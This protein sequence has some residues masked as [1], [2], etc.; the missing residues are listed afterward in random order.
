MESSP[1]S[2][3][4]LSVINSPTKQLA[5]CTK[6]LVGIAL[7]VGLW[8]RLVGFNYP[9]F[10]SHSFRQTQTLST[11]EAF[12][13]HGI[14]PLHP[15]TIYMGYPGVFVLEFPVFQALAALLYHIFGPHLELVRILNILMGIA[16]AWLLFKIVS[17]MLD[18]PTAIL[19]ALTYWLAPLNILYQRSM[20][21]DPTAVCC[22]LLAFYMLLLLTS[23]PEEVLPRPHWTYLLTFA[24]STW[25]TAMI[26]AL[27]LWPAVM[28]F[29]FVFLTRRCK[30]DGLILGIGAAFALS[31]VCFLTWNHY[32]AGINNASPITS[33]VNPTALLG[34]SALTQ[35]E[36][37]FIML[38]RR[39]KLWLGLFGALLYIV[40]LWAAWNERGE[41][42]RKRVLMLLFLIPPSYLILFASI[43][44]P[45][46]YYQLIITPFLA[47]ITG[48]GLR[49]LATRHLS[50][51]TLKPAISRFVVVTGSSLLIT[52]AA[53]FYLLWLQAPHIDGRILKF[54]RVCA[55]K[56]QPGAAAMVFV[57]RSLYTISK[58]SYI[59]EFLYASKLW[60]YGR[61]VENAMDARDLYEEALPGFQRLDYVVFYGTERPDWLP[62]KHFR[63]AIDDEASRLYA[64]KRITEL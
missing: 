35:P 37:Y 45:H 8:L 41:Q 7:A 61:T 13:T 40:G 27:Y 42:K 46:E 11:I 24:V 12:Y 14:D 56:F 22:A 29:G 3:P 38:V 36:F 5:I 39:P 2:T 25:L 49:W 62:N 44:R 54:Q 52:S 33:G 48:N 31:G 28:L 47:I 21:I 20:L 18:R 26:K 19:A 6:L 57:D 53:L 10:D 59:P 63:L 58:H 43:N 15:R 17:L 51:K 9:P 64:F 1:V 16:G 30:L 23:R 32:A 50:T 60:G 34:F 4:L 55:G